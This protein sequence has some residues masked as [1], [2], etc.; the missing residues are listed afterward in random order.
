MSQYSGIPL[1]NLHYISQ[2]RYLTL[3]FRIKCILQKI[4]KYVTF[5]HFLTHSSRV[6]EYKRGMIYIHFSIIRTTHGT[7][8]WTHLIFKWIRT[9]S[10]TSSED[11]IHGGRL[12]DIRLR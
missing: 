1:R 10:I 2:M 6:T 9:A 5:T 11:N 12:E 3:I 4:R 8:E 7:V